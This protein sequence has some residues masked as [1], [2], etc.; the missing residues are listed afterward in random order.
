MTGY[1]TPGRYAQTFDIPISLPQTELRRG[2]YIIVGQIQLALGQ[3]MRIRC[4]NLHLVNIITPTAVPATFNTALGIV[5]AGIFLGPMFCS[6]AALL[7]S[8]SPGIISM[9]PFQFQDFATPGLYTV[10]VSNN[11][12]N[13][14]VSVLLTG[15]AKILST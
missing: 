14:D 9:N 11:T 5:S 2:R 6:S 4:L 13:V 10:V 7:S 15:V 12:S 1:I 8:S 3:A